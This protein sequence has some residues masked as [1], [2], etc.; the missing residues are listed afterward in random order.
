MGL[1]VQLH[2][3]ERGSLAL[4]GD[5]SLVECD[6]VSTD[7]MLRLPSTLSYQLEVERIGRSLLAQGTLELEIDCTCVRCLREFSRPVRIE[8]WICQVSLEGAD[9]A[10]IV[11]DCVDLTPYLRED[12]FL[13]LPAHPVCEPGCAGLP[14]AHRQKVPQTGGECRPLGTTSP[15]EALDKLKF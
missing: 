6:I 10:P 1:Q 2:R 3:L 5:L 14:L 8:R 13:A 12:I 15:W 9:R 4:A 7:S 11:N